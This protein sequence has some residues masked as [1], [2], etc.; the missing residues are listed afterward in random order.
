MFEEEEPK[1]KA[2]RELGTDLSGLSIEDLEEYVED[3]KAEIDRVN[4][5]IESK[6]AVQGEAAALF[7]R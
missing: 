7:K 3:L 1:K 6:R 5:T 2:G 4:E